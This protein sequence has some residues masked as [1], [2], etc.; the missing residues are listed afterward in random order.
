MS[1]PPLCPEKGKRDKSLSLLLWPMECGLDTQ[2][3]PRKNQC[4]HTHIHQI[5][6]LSMCP[7]NVFGVFWCVF[8][9]WVVEGP[10]EPH[11]EHPVSWPSPHLAT[12]TTFRFAADSPVTPNTFR[13]P[14]SVRKLRLSLQ[15]TSHLTSVYSSVLNTSNNLWSSPLIQK[16]NYMNSL[17]YKFK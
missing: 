3:L 7:Y 1:L 11:E 16:S 15:R 2:P 8:P 12:A 4:C 6:G 14:C 17:H 10:A 9:F 5:A 13:I